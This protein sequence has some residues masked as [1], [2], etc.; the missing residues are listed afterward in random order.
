MDS[1]GPTLC[2]YKNY[3]VVWSASQVYLCNRKQLVEKLLLLVSIPR[4][5][6]Q[7]F[8]S[9]PQVLFGVG[10]IRAMFQMRN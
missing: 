1:D 5:S 6:Y 10:S 7:L 8:H 3:A 2:I 4:N 9:T